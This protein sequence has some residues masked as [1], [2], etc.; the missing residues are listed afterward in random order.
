MRVLRLCWLGIPTSEYQPMVEL[1]RDV[2]GL[3]VE[4]AE[5]TTT[6]L[7]LPSGDRVQVFAANLSQSRSGRLE[8]VVLGRRTTGRQGSYKKL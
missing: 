6:E 8:W 4:F 2:M 5:P 7:S 1:L 3:A